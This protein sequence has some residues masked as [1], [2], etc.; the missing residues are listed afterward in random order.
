M[1]VHQFVILTIL[2]NVYVLGTQAMNLSIGHTVIP[3]NYHPTW[4]QLVTP[5]ILSKT[6]ISPTSTYPLWYN[7]IAP[8]VPLNPS[9]YLAYLIGTNK[10]DPLIFRNYIGHVCGY[11][12]PLSK[13]HVVPPTYIHVQIH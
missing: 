6:K 3:I 1:N 9:L 8:F 4:Q 10:F 11:V 2:P 7:G 12:Y 13:Q 5:I